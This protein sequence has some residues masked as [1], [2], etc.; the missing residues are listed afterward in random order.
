MISINHMKTGSI[1]FLQAVLV[2]IGVGVLALMLAE[3][4]FEGVNAGATTLKQVYFDDLFLAYAYTASIAFFAAL[5]QGFKLLGSV[6]QGQ[7]FSVQSIKALRTIKR[8]AMLMVLFVFGAEI[9]IFVNRGNDDIAGGV[10]I[11]LIMA[12]VSSIAAAAASVFGSALQRAVN[13]KTEND[14]TV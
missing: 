11:G 6:A 1:R 10:M 12:I 4:W 14:L 3:P 2:L 9:F 5:Y 7:V 13:M 8:C